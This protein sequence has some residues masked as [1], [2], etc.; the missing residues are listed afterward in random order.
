LIGVSRNR[1]G[2][3]AGVGTPAQADRTCSPRGGYPP[4][5]EPRFWFPLRGIMLV[6]T[7]GGDGS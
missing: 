4:G 6:A 3:E 2:T 1:N 5:R 7:P